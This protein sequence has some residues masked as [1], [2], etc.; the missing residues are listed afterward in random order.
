MNGG[1]YHQIHEL[2]WHLRNALEIECIEKLS[3]IVTI[4]STPEVPYE[5]D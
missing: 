3:E 4:L 5:F 1:Y 2:K